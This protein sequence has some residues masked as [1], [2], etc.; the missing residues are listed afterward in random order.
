MAPKFL[1]IIYVCEGSPLHSSSST[2]IFSEEG[3]IQKVEW[4]FSQRRRKHLLLI[5]GAQVGAGVSS[6]A[7]TAVSEG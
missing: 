6:A 7:T 1:N 2:R 5:P 4:D 3:P